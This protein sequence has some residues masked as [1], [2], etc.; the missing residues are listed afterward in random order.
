MQ[1]RRALRFERKIEEVETPDFIGVF[2]DADKFRGHRC[3]R[4]VRLAPRASSTIVETQHVVSIGAR[5]RLTMQKHWFFCRA[6]VIRK[7]CSRFPRALDDIA[8][9][10]WLGGQH[11]EEAKDEDEVSG[12][13]GRE[14]DQAPEEEEVTTR[15][16]P[17]FDFV[18]RR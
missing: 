12:E 3:A 6:V 16:F 7:Q 5:A 14:E 10:S 11:G 9:H 13:K 15:C 2:E 1:Q 17:V 4:A 8:T 18:R